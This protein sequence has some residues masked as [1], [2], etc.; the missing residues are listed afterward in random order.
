VS[1][2]TKQPGASWAWGQT[3]GLFNDK[4]MEF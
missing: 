2:G 1:K 4:Y 3:L